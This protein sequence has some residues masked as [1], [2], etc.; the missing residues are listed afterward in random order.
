[1]VNLLIVGQQKDI[2]RTRQWLGMANQKDINAAL[3]E[4]GSLVFLI[5]AY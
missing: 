2:T 4:N 1:L 3:D 5:D